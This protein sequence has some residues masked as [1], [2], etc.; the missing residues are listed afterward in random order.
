MIWVGVGQG[1]FVLHFLLSFPEKNYNYPL[2]RENDAMLLN[3]T[4]FKGE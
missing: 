3:K 4:K 2:T 1:S